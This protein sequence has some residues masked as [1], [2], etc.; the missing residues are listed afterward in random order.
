MS[1]SDARTLHDAA[2][3]A[4]GSAMRRRAVSLPTVAIVGRPNVGKS[5]FFNRILGGRRAIVDSQPG[6]TRDIHFGE[7]EWTGHHFYVVDTGGII[8][9]AAGMDET[10]RRQALLAVEEA[11]VIVF[12]V[13]GHEGVH[14]LDQHI[15]A[16]LRE[17]DA[18]TLLV[19]NKVDNLPD[20]TEHL[21]F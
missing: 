11:S 12:M 14:P 10:I 5:T 21:E 4:G 19:V 13:D 16:L 15:A 3:E 9:D 8:E 17:R 7:A 6:V 20:A 2:A 18:R 1:L